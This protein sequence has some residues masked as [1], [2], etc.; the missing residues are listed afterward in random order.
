MCEFPFKIVDTPP[1]PIPATTQLT[2]VT[3]IAGVVTVVTLELRVEELIKEFDWASVTPNGDG[4]LE[5]DGD[6]LEEIR[7]EFDDLLNHE[8]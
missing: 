7:D 3:V 8:D 6:D 5:V 2:G 4:V 1:V